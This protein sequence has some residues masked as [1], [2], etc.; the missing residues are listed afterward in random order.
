MVEY[1]NIMSMNIL[2]IVVRLAPQ[3]VDII[4]DQWLSHVNTDQQ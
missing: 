2:M 1:N 4:T 3:C